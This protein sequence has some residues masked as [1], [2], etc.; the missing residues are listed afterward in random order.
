M[1]LSASVTIGV[2]VQQL[3]LD[4]VKVG[5]ES[6]VHFG[7]A[8]EKVLKILKRVPAKNQVEGVQPAQVSKKWTNR[9][10]CARAR[11]TPC[12]RRSVHFRQ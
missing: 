4:F 10:S 8:F 7:L 3:P 9:A 5:T 11:K 6:I 2:A 1:T 12:H